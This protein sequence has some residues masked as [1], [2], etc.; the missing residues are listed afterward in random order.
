MSSK[1]FIYVGEGEEFSFEKLR[2]DFE[3]ITGVFDINGKNLTDSLLACRY[4][5]DNYQ[6]TVCVE[7]DLETIMSNETAK[8]V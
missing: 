5:F 3:L 2:R 1:M 4:T 6:V 7:N 8:R